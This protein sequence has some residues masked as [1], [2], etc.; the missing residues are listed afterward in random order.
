[1]TTVVLTC[2][3]FLIV[4][5]AF[6]RFPSNQIQTFLIVAIA[7]ERSLSNQIQIFLDALASHK[8]MFKIK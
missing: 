2:Q 4:A 3:T 1:M 5:I 8:T 7:F 6:E